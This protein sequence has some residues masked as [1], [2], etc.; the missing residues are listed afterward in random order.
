MS[1]LG[2]EKYYIWKL[3][4]PFFEVYVFYMH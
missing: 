2:T 1:H 3:K 4:F